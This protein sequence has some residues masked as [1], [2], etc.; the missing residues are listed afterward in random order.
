MKTIVSYLFLVSLMAQVFAQDD[1][2]DVRSLNKKNDRI[3][4]NLLNNQWQN[5]SNPMQ[6]MPVSL[7]ID[8]YTFEQLLKKNRTFNISL[9]LGISSKNFHNNSLPY[10]SLDITYFKLIPGGYEYTKNKLNVTYL[11]APLEIDFVT[12]SDK[13]NRNLKIAVGG[14]VGI[15]LTNYI[16]YVGED[17]RNHSNQIVKFKEYR[18]NNINPYH[19]GI[20]FRLNYGRF[21]IIGN[22]CLSSLFKENKG[23]NLITFSYGFSISI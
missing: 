18:I 6:Q 16:K 11:D 21:G 14:L 2:T 10:D 12:N 13:R 4:I 19:Y 15:M 8:I 17:F 22:Y 23:P 3:T 9:G 1:T 5:I 7:G 20:Y